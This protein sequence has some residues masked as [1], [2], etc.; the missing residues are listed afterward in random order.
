MLIHRFRV[1]I[2]SVVIDAEAG[3][4]IGVRPGLPGL[5]LTR[6]GYSKQGDLVAIVEIT[7]RGDLARY[8]MDFEAHL[9]DEG[10]ET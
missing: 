9:V 4:L 7:T 8:V 2:E 5:G 6:D 1:T 10:L 3:T